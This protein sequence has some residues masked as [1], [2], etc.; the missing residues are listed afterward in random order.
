MCQNIFSESVKKKGKLN[1][2]GEMGGRFPVD[3]GFM[4]D[5][6]FC[7]TRFT[8]VHDKRTLYLWRGLKIIFYS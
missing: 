4:F 3:A 7:D 1:C 5:K 2:R 8:E 6:S